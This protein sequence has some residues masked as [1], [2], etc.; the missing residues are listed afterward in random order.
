MI[1]LKIF[2]NLGIFL[3]ILGILEWQTGCNGAFP[4]KP[5][6]SNSSMLLLGVVAELAAAAIKPPE[7]VE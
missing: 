1:T 3:P 6:S 4:F 7:K 2:V 5:L